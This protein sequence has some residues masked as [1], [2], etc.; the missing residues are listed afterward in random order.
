MLLSVKEIAVL[1]AEG[2]I[3]VITLQTP[4]FSVGGTGQNWHVSTPFKHHRLGSVE[5]TPTHFTLPKI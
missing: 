3:L 1:K 5:L 2:D 4:K